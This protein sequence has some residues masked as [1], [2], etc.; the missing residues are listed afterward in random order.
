MDLEAI[1]QRIA[2]VHRG[3]RWILNAEV[4][5]A[6]TPLVEQLA[7]W[8]SG[9]MM[10]VA[11]QEGVGELP[12][13][14][15]IHY[16]RSRGATVM[17]AIRAFVESAE[18][19]S[20]ELLKAVEGFDPDAE[21]MNLI[22]GF[23]RMHELYGRP[24]YGVRPPSWSAFED[25]MLIDELCDA[26]GIARAP[27]AIVAATDAAAAATGLVSEL[28]TV[29][30]A[31]N[32]E[33]WHG[34]G[35]YVRWV[36]DDVTAARATEW[37]SVHADRVRVMPFLDG[38]P[39]SIHG[40]NTGEGTAVFLPVELMILRD[41]DAP[42]FVY[43]RAANFWDPPDWITRQM[44]AAARSMGALL[45]ERSGY[46]GGF[47][48]DGV[49]N[50]DGFFPT[51][52]NPRLSV[53]HHLQASAADV[54][55]GSMERLLIAGDLDVDAADLEHTVVAAAADRRSGAM[56]VPLEGDY[57]PVETG[58]DFTHR[59]AVATAADEADASMRIGSATFGSILLVRL[60]SERNPVG[61]QVAP[62]AA[63][64]VELAR[65]LWGVDLPRLRPAPDPF[66]D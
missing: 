41:V 32:R 42:R 48:I 44:R 61:P 26:A 55:L 60:D 45:A 28:G 11:A 37:F 35:A 7:G 15:R 13:A 54:P 49:A 5:A 38:I 46:R 23:S 20:A 43:A 19:P 58:V 53:G 64:A 50:G 56:L 62:R 6:A 21:A 25:K 59:G 52:L 16:T 66:R 9:P 29:W 4:A 2:D 3:R 40:F 10:V 27:S 39:C 36:P 34:G 18:E 17:A 33:G 12:E 65:A 51:E 24:V 31:D 30:V 1:N 14:D 22:A 8:G 47:G 63:Q 57:E